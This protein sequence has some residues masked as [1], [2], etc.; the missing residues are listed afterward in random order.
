MLNFS[1]NSKK[2]IFNHVDDNKYL[3][4]KI[5]S[6]NNYYIIYTTKGNENQKIISKKDNAICNNKISLGKRYIIETTSIFNFKIKSG[7]TVKE[8]K[9]SVNIDCMILDE[10]KFCKEPNLGIY[11]VLKAKNIKGLCYDK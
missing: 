9:N 3:V 7:D 4:T 1:C 6:L 11:D 2:R 8:I 10:I 5:D